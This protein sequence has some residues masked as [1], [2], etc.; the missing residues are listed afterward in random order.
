MRIT[1]ILTLIAALLAGSLAWAQQ[2]TPC[3]APQRPDV[4]D[5][6]QATQEQM[7]QGGQDVRDYVQAQQQRLKCLERKEAE[8]GE[9]I[10]EEQKALINRI[11]NKT[12]NDMQTVADEYNEQV[13]VWK[14]EAPESAAGGGGEAGS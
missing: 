2:D 7:V 13:R 5:G 3:E 8:L 14:G 11:Y 6:A 1:R 10:T 4:P 12:V 9:E